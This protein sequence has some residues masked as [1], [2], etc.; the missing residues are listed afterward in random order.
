MSPELQW[1]ELPIE[2]GLWPKDSE[3]LYLRG[4]AGDMTPTLLTEY[5]T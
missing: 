4:L 5:G 1:G 3:Q 2:L